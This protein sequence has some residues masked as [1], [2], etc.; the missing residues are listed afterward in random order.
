MQLSS[1]TAANMECSVIRRGNHA[2]RSPCPLFKRA[3]QS[4]SI[5]PPQFGQWNSH[6]KRKHHPLAEPRSERPANR[7]HRQ[8]ITCAAAARP[9]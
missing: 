5:S 8:M 3:I 1:R 9:G 4:A 2:A 6:H 7:S